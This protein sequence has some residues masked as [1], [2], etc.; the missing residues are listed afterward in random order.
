MGKRSY[1]KGTPA[2]FFDADDKEWSANVTVRKMK[3]KSKK[4]EPS[5]L[6]VWVGRVYNEDKSVAYDVYSRQLHDTPDEC[7][8]EAAMLG[9]E[10]DE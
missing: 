1:R 7:Y 6:Y 3:N 10:T 5:H 8:E 2:K 9:F 4:A